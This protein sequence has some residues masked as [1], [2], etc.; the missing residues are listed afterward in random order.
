M[1]SC[2]QGISPVNIRQLFPDAELFGA[3]EV[4]LWECVTDIRKLRRG[5]GFAALDTTLIDEAVARG[6]GCILTQERTDN[7]FR[8][9]PD[10]NLVPLCQV[11]NVQRAYAK[12][13]QALYRFPGNRMELIGITGT[14]GKTMTSCLVAGILGAAGKNVGMMGS[15]G[16]FD[17]VDASPTPIST[18]PPKRVASW[19]SRMEQNDCSHVVME[20]SSQ[21]LDQYRL[22]GLEFSTLCMTNVCREHLDLHGTIENYRK[23]KMRMFEYLAEKGVALLNADDP[24]LADIPHWLDIPVLTY[25]VNEE[26]DITAIPI[27]QTRSEQTILV[28]AGNASLPLCTKI[29]GTHFVYDSLAAVAVGLRLGIDLETIVRG[30]ESVQTIPGRMERIECGQPFGVF[31]DFAHTPNELE[32]TLESLRDVTR[33]RILCVFGARGDRDPEKRPLMGK[34]ASRLADHVVLTDTHPADECPDKIIDDILS[35]MKNTQDVSIYHRRRDAICYALSQ[36]QPGDCV[37][38][39]GR[40]HEKSPTPDRYDDRDFI[41]KWLYKNQ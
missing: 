12:L 40:G 7:P 2:F 39:A 10:G 24:I 11:E 20:V 1:Q 23:I 26:A 34:I 9:G 35:G 31:L 22:E 17:G 6:A 18:L 36:A 15:L 5:D 30:I 33:G 41:R 16:C 37:L 13:C 38:I 29:I 4:S 28:T 27:E 32:N 25:G 21:A 19:L 14:S 8:I 3:D